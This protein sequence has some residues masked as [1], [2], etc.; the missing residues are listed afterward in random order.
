ML[1][2]DQEDFVDPQSK[3]SK[4]FRRRFRVSFKVFKEIVDLA[5]EWFPEDNRSDCVG[6][7]ARPL[8][9]KILG[10][11][12][13]LGRACTF[14]DIEELTNIHEETHRV[15]FHKFVKMF[16]EELYAKWVH[17]PQDDVTLK[18]TLDGYSRVGL[19]GCLFSADC[20]HVPWASVLA[21]NRVDHTNGKNGKLGPTLSFE[22][23][24]DLLG[25]IMSTTSAHPGTTSDIAPW[26]V[27][28]RRLLIF[29]E[30]N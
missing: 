2:R 22:V 27:L 24:C 10:V 14:D 19:P 6:N 11:L 1:T 28:T 29:F 17:F 4:T 15:F 16:A 25:F 23:C 21:S 12:R 5:Y 3:A 30:V 9:L 13:K 26:R 18:Y 8:E 7:H 20:T